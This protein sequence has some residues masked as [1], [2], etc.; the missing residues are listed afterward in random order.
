MY[1]NG[2]WDSTVTADVLKSRDGEK[3]WY[4]HE[5]DRL[6]KVEVTGYQSIFIGSREIISRCRKVGTVR[7]RAGGNVCSETRYYAPA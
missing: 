7:L 6:L 4:V 2:P 1:R 3:Y 5:D